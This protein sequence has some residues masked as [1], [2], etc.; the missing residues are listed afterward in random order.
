MQGIQLSKGYISK[1]PHF[2]KHP[3]LDKTKSIVERKAP[4]IM[5][6]ADLH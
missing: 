5:P 2:R 1:H 3:E 6:H 4:L